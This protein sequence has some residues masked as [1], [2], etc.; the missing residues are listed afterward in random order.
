MLLPS[1]FHWLLLWNC[2][3]LKLEIS[4]DN[5]ETAVSVAKECTIID[6]NDVTVEVNLINERNKYPELV[7]T[8]LQCQENLP[9]VSLIYHLGSCYIFVADSTDFLKKLLVK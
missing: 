6:Y 9:N 1:A 8:V 5:V 3:K 4:G 7:Y 2:F